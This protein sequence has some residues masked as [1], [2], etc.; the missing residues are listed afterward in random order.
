MLRALTRRTWGQTRQRGPPVSLRVPHA[1]FSLLQQMEGAPPPLHVSSVAPLQGASFT[2]EV[3]SGSWARRR[4]C[5]RSGTAA[6]SAGG[7][8]SKSASA[9]ASAERARAGSMLETSK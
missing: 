4:A 9:K 2:S 7:S 8:A 5:R 3:G 6:A 1:K